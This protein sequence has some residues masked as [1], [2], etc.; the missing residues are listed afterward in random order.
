MRTLTDEKPPTWQLKSCGASQRGPMRLRMETT[1]RISSSRDI[2]WEQLSNPA[3]VAHSHG[4][5][6]VTSTCHGELAQP[7]HWEDSR[8]KPW[9][10]HTLPR[11]EFNEVIIGPRFLSTY[12]LIIWKK[13][14]EAIVF[15]L[16]G[17]KHKDVFYSGW[18]L[19]ANTWVDTSECVTGSAFTHQQVTDTFAK[20]TLPK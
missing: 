8:G 7:S 3:I 1:I 20:I 4:W 13:S 5:E 19:P 2:P 6:G 12:L 14:P 10:L 15:L 16:Y 17:F 18:L 11:I 9:M